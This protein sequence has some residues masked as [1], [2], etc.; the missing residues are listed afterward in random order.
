MTGR[1]HRTSGTLA[2]LQC[3]RAALRHSSPKGVKLKGDHGACAARAHTPSQLP[4]EILRPG[5]TL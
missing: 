4:N 2:L 3:V 1:T 5:G